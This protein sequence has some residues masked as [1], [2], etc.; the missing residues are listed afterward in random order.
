[1]S[2]AQLV[3]KHGDCKRHDDGFDSDLC[4]CGCVKIQK[5]VTAEEIARFR[6]EEEEEEAETDT[7]AL[8][9]ARA[10]NARANSMARA[11]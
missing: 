4:T 11:V 10:V 9:H 8:S 3:V 5:F 7:R 2:A 6:R 1:M